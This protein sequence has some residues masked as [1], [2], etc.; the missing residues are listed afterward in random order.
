M[1]DPWLEWV[2]FN[3]TIGDPDQAQNI[4]YGYTL[5]WQRRSGTYGAVVASGYLTQREARDAA[6]S[7]AL[8]QG[9]RG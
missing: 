5:E 7:E 9:W 2:K 3:F 4:R 8:D 6:L 1:H